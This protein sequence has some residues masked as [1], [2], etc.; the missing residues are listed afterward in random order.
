VITTVL[1]D[2]DGTLYDRDRLIQRLAETQY[3][4]FV[5]ELAHVDRQRF[6]SRLVALDDHGYRRKDE[7]YAELGAELG[8]EPA[9]QARLI[10]HFWASYDAH[11]ELPD[12]ALSTLETLRARGTRLGIVTNGSVERQSS[13]IDALGIRSLFETILISEQEGVRKPDSRIFH[14]ALDRCGTVPSA[15]LFVGDHPEADIKGALNAGLAAAWV[16]VPY[17]EPPD[18]AVP[19]IARL[20]DVLPLV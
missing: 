7:V 19:R 6:V 13:K 1:F 14:R 3:G 8:L 17:W 12:D 2:L 4:D 20:G 10:D 5:R 11:C 15:A 9:L 16:V 18:A